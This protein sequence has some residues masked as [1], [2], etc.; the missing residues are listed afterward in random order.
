MSKFNDTVLLL[1]IRWVETGKITLLRDHLLPIV[2]YQ[3]D[4]LPHFNAM[5][6][7]DDTHIVYQEVKKK[8]ASND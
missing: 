3:N 1:L 2:E 8:E 4:L 5:V 7:I 6:L